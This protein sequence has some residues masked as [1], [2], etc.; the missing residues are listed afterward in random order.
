MPKKLHQALLKRAKRKG[1][2][3]SRAKKYVYGTMRKSGWK[4]KREKK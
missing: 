3:G 4:P 1:L 2:S